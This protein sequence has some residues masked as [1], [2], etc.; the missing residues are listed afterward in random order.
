MK[1][2]RGEGEMPPRSA[3]LTRFFQLLAKR[4]FASAERMLKRV[5]E[6][7][8]STE[9]DRGYL[10]ALSGMLR[11]Q[12]S[13]EQSAFISNLKD[14]DEKW[15]QKYRREFLSDARNKLFADYDRGFF[16]AWADYM[17]ILI[18]MEKEKTR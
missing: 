3:F 15:L 9:R 4:K 17:R 8:H 12:R 5:V 1:I 10:Q 2:D 13:G 16:S 7:A 18:K 14:K 11:S 6:K